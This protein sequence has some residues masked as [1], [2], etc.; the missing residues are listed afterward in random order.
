MFFSKVREKNLFLSFFL[1]V[2]ALFVSFGITVSAADI[3]ITSYVEGGLTLTAHGKWGGNMPFETVGFPLD[4]D[5]WLSSFS[6]NNQDYIDYIDDTGTPGFHIKW[7]LTNF[8]YSGS[9]QTQGPISASNFKLFAKHNGTAAS[10]LT[11]G[12][13]DPSKNLSILPNSCA[14]ATVDTFT[15]HGNFTD[16]GQSYSLAGSTTDQVL[17]SSTVDCVNIGH[18]RF[19]MAQLIVPQSSEIGTYTSHLTWTVVDGLP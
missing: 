19:D 10:A 6:D 1:A 17:V 7:K 18:I 11:K 16:S 5:Y 2:L 8:I 12:Y 14:S 9:S 13:D 4:G 3:Q 15:F